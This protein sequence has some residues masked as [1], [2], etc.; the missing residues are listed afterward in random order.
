VI[1]QC[2]PDE[3]RRKSTPTGRELDQFLAREP[4]GAAATAPMKGP[5]EA[6]LVST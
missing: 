2:P 1:A 6:G 3:L 4:V 5:A